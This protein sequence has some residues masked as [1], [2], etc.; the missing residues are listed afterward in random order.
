MYAKS[1]DFWPPPPFTNLL[2]ADLYYQGSNRLCRPDLVL[3]FF[4]VLVLQRGSMAAYSSSP[5]ARR[6]QE[7]EISSTE[8]IVNFPPPMCTR[9]H[10]MDA[11]LPL[12]IMSMSGD[13]DL[14][15]HLIFLGSRVQLFSLHCSIDFEPK[16]GIRGFQFSRVSRPPLIFSPAAK[17]LQETQGN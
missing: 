10:F 16:K 1:G 2:S 17:A 4:Q 7:L 12:P 8:S 15:V 3:I 9:T 6:K 11:H 5:P 14:N 13:D